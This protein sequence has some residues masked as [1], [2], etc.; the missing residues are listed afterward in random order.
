MPRSQ[1]HGL[2][3]VGSSVGVG[4]ERFFVGSARLITGPLTTILLDS[5]YSVAGAAFGLCPL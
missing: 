5:T 1:L 3:G 4:L 2:P